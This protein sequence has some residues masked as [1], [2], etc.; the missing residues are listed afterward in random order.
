VP[1]ISNSSPLILYARIGRLELLR[2]VF[3]E[4]MVPASVYDEVVVRGAGMSGATAVASDAWIRRQAVAN[5]D[6]IE[7]FLG[8]VDVGEAEAIA[9]ATE[10]GGEVVVILDDRK[11]RRLARARQV[12]IVGSAGVLLLAKNHGVI[13]LVRPVLDE[14]RAAGLRLGDLAYHRALTDAGESTR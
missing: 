4:L 13:P 6:L 11:G 14:L 9:L 12:E 8:E 1:T 5:R 10:I 3:G 2:R 7:L